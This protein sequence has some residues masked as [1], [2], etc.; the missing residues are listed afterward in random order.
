[1]TSVSAA[2]FRQVDV[3]ASL[4]RDVPRILYVAAWLA[5]II[6]VRAAFFYPIFGMDSHAY[7]EAW[8]RTSLYT[9][10]PG[11]PNAYLYSPAFAQAMWPAAH[12]PWPV[13]KVAYSALELVLLVWLLRPLGWRWVV[14]LTLAGL[15]EVADGNIY[16]L[17]A[18]ACVVGFRH[19]GTWAFPLVTK[20]A[21]G[22][23]PLWFAVRRERRSLA[24]SLGLTAAVVT[25]SAVIDPLAW[26]AWGHLLVASAS[27][28]TAPTGAFTVPLVFRAPLGIALVWWGGRRGWRWTLPI[29]MVLCSPVVFFGTYTLLAAIPRV[30]WPERSCP[31]LKLDIRKRAR[32]GTRLGEGDKR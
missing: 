11:T 12:L 21:P 19:P 22:L 25:V 13:F 5:A 28:A 31:V 18:V 23:G 1:M 27:G 20:I 15:A 10:A 7:W 16:V 4:R 9:T 8:H 2:L 30:M 24:I 17:M 29:G 32:R 26:L 3:R 6:G 14:P